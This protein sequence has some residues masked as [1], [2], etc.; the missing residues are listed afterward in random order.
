MRPNGTKRKL[1]AGQPTVGILL[2]SVSPLAAEAVSNVGFDWA[3]IDLQHGEPDLAN[4]TGLLQAVSTTGTTPFVRVPANDFML[5]GRALD[6]GAY[7]IVVPLVNTVAEAEA[8]VRAAKYPPRG[9]R[10]MGPIRGAIYG[11][12][13]YFAESNDEIALIVMIETV[14]AIRNVR[15]IVAVEGIDGCYIGPSDLGISYSV[16][17]SGATSTAPADQLEE[18]IAIILA[19]CQEA[20]KAAGFP[21]ANAETANQRI[22]QGFRFVSISSDV[23]LMRSAVAAEFNAVER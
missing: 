23:A 7:G 22:R 13:N 21:A 10:S 8:A 19:A 12:D 9:A 6:L 14:E 20:G 11:G 1:L 5:I 3:L 18:G 4:V 17:G 2:S 15:E 16:E